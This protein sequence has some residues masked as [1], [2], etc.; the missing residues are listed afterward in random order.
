M[1]DVAYKTAIDQRVLETDEKQFTVFDLPPDTC[2][3][4]EHEHCLHDDPYDGG[5]HVVV[6]PPGGPSERCKCK[7]QSGTR[8]E[9]D[10]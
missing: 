6:T 1:S 2:R 10:S 8:R 9:S 5:C 3:D 4:C 7:K